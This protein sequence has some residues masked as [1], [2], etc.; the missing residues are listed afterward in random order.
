M[1][2]KSSSVKR[3]GVQMQM[4]MVVVVVRREESDEWVVSVS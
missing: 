2:Q 3:L 1:V 4:Q